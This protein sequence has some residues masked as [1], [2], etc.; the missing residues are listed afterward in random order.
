M[1]LN[2]EVAGLYLSTKSLNLLL[3]RDMNAS[4]LSSLNLSS[5]YVDLNLL[6]V[7]WGLSLII[8]HKTNW[9]S[10]LKMQALRTTPGN[11]SLV[12]CSGA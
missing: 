8:V 12:K 1:P 2:L 10:C 6:N 3:T 11:I 9:E 7:D 5:I 4:R